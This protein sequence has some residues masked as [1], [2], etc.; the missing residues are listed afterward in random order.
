MQHLE[1][2]FSRQ[3]ITNMEPFIAAQAEKLDRRLKSLSG[4]G[5]IVHIDHAL[6]AMTGD[7]ICRVSCGMEAGLLDDPDFSPGWCVTT[8]R[9]PSARSLSDTNACS[10]TN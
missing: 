8:C 10:G 3:S 5:H 6:T 2:F 7:I 1:G 9:R 4:T